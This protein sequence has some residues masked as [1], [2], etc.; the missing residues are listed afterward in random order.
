MSRAAVATIAAVVG[1]ILTLLAAVAVWLDSM[2]L[3]AIYA[4]LL[5]LAVG[6]LSWLA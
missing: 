4:A 5:G 2:L 6:S 1:G 3:A